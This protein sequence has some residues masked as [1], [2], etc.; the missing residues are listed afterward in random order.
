M[1]CPRRASIRRAARTKQRGYDNQ[2]DIGN[3]EQ[4]QIGRD[5]VNLSD[6]LAE[7]GV[8]FR[9]HLGGNYE[10]GL[11]QE[12]DRE[13]RV[14]DES[15]ADEGRAQQKIGRRAEERLAQQSS[16]VAEDLRRELASQ[17]RGHHVAGQ[18]QT[19]EAGAHQEGVNRA[20][21]AR[22]G[23]ASA[24]ERGQQMLRLQ[25]WRGGP[26]A[27]SGGRRGRV[28]GRTNRQQKERQHSRRGRVPKS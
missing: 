17:E 16:V 15:V 8:S 7:A 18:V 1:V 28:Q 23:A 9:N 19:R 26:R 10:R 22:R 12:H 4:R 14:K 2:C 21:D 24:A 5:K 27:S 11:H 6:E 20:N 25:L 13:I 3:H